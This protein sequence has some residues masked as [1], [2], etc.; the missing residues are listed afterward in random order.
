MKTKRFVSIFAAAFFAIGYSGSVFASCGCD[1]DG[2]MNVHVGISGLSKATF[3]SGGNSI[4]L[5]ESN[6]T[7]ILKVRMESGTNTIT[8]NGSFDDDPDPCDTAGFSMTG[9]GL[10]FDGE[11][12]GSKGWSGDGLI[13]AFDPE[14]FTVTARN[15][16]PSNPQGGRPNGTGGIAGGEAGGGSPNSG[17]LSYTQITP[18][19]GSVAVTKQSEPFAILSR[20]P[21]GYDAV[22]SSGDYLSMGNLKFYFHM[23]STKPLFSH[24]SVA[25]GGFDETNQ[26]SSAN[27]VFWRSTSG[28]P[29]ILVSP[30]GAFRLEE[31]STGVKVEMFNRPDY[32]DTTGSINTGA[33]AVSTYLFDSGMSGLTIKSWI[34]RSVT[35]DPTSVDS[36]A[37]VGSNTLVETAKG[38]RTTTTVVDD[39]ASAVLTGTPSA[40]D[41]TIRD[42]DRTVSREVV[43]LLVSGEP[44]ISKTIERFGYIPV[45]AWNSSASPRTLGTTIVDI[46][47]VRRSLHYDFN[48]DGVEADEP[49]ESWAYYGE[50][51][52]DL[53][54]SNY[55][56]L[57]EMKLHVETD[58][59]WTVYGY[60]ND[61]D[62]T[63]EITYQPWGD[64]D[65]PNLA[66]IPTIGPA[67][68][69]ASFGGPVRRTIRTIRRAPDTVDV[70][71]TEVYVNGGVT[72]GL[73]TSSS[74][75]NPVATTETHTKE[76]SGEWN[77]TTGN[78]WTDFSQAT[79]GKPHRMVVT[80]YG[81][82]DTDADYQYQNEGNFRVQPFQS[83]Q[84][85]SIYGSTGLILTETR[86]LTDWIGSVVTEE[87]FEPATCE[88][89]SYDSQNRLSEVKRDGR[90]IS[91][92]QY[93]SDLE[94]VETDEHGTATLTRWDARGRIVSRT[95]LGG[96]GVGDITTSYEYLGLEIRSRI[97]GQLVGRQ[98]VDMLGRTTF[99]EDQTGGI[100]TWLYSNQGRTVTVVR[101]DTGT[102]ITARHRDGKL[103]SVTGTGVVHKNYYYSFN[104]GS[105]VKQYLVTEKVGGSESDRMTTTVTSSVVDGDGNWEVEPSYI[106]RPNAAT[107]AMDVLATM[108]P[109]L[110]RDYGAA[111]NM[112]KMD[113]SNTTVGGSATYPAVNSY[114]TKRTRGGTMG[115]HTFSGKVAAWGTNRP[116]TGGTRLEE[117]HTYYEKDEHTGYWW[118]KTLVRRGIEDGGSTVEILNGVRLWQQDGVETIAVQNGESV[119]T[120]T[121][122]DRAAK[123]STRISDSTF[124]EGIADV[125]VETVN[126]YTQWV[127]G[128]HSAVAGHRLIYTYDSLG[129][130]TAVR[131]HRGAV[132]RTVYN[133]LG[134]VIRSVDALGRAT[135][136]DY[137]AP[138]NVG[139]GQV[140]AITKP[141]GQTSIYA[142]NPRGQVI[143]IGGSAEYP[144]SFTYNFYGERETMTTT[145]DA[146]NSVTRW[147]YNSAGLLRKKYYNYS[148]GAN[149][150]T[151]DSITYVYDPFGR[152]M[153][154]TVTGGKTTSYTYNDFDEIETIDYGDDGAADVTLARNGAGNVTGA[155]ENYEDADGVTIGSGT[156]NYSYD[157]G[158]LDDVTYSSGHS[159]LPN[160]VLDYGTHEDGRPAGYEIKR[161][162][163]TDLG[164]TYAYDDQGRLE[165]VGSVQHGTATYAYH[166]GSGVVAGYTINS[167]GTVLTQ[168]R[169]VDFQGRISSVTSKSRFS[170]V[171]AS[172]SYSYDMDDRR[173]QVRRED[174]SYWNYG[175]NFR[176]EVTL[177]TRHTPSGL[178]I[179][180]LER[181]YNYDDLGNRKWAKFGGGDNGALSESHYTINGHNQYT[182]TTN[183]YDPV[184]NTTQPG[185]VWV[186]GRAPALEDVHVNG[187][188][189]TR[190]E[191]WFSKEL[192]VANSLVPVKESVLVEDSVGA[193]ISS[194]NLE[195]SKADNS[196]IGYDKAGNLANDG[197]WEYEW[198]SENRLRK[199]KPTD[200]AVTA[201]MA[202]QIVEFV[203][204]WQGKRI[205]KKV[206]EGAT[207]RQ[208]RY[209]YEGWNVVAEWTLHGSSITL[210][211]P[212]TYLWGL[213]LAGQQ[214]GNVGRLQSAGGV[215]GLLAAD[216]RKISDATA[217][218]KL[219]AS[220]DGNGNI[221]AWSDASGMVSRTQDYDAFGNVVLKEKASFGPLSTGGGEIAYG[222]STKPEDSESG[223]L[224]YGYRYYDPV[225][226]RW[227]SRDPIEERGGVN[228]YA[229]LRNRPCNDV[230]VLG[231]QS[232]YDQNNLPIHPSQVPDMTKPIPPQG[233]DKTLRLGPL[234]PDFLAGLLK[235]SINI[236]LEVGNSIPLGN[237][238]GV[239]ISGSWGF[240]GKIVCCRG[241]NGGV[242]LLAEGEITFG[243]GAGLG[244]SASQKM[245]Q[246]VKP[247]EIKPDL[248]LSSDSPPCKDTIP[249]VVLGLTMSGQAG[250]TGLSGAP[251]GQLLFKV[252]E[253]SASRGWE[254][255]VTEPPIIQM[256]S[257]QGASIDLIGSVSLNGKKVIKQP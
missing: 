251:G 120:M 23:G 124:V 26:T 38:I 44:V 64:T 48:G 28:N 82:K 52:S 222:F 236:G 241:V 223:L 105:S 126:G 193:H 158:Q 27:K 5:T 24:F 175:Y 214:N 254:W 167:S 81:T 210:N 199:M 141:N 12:V 72:V 213:D 125:V 88:T 148:T 103:L 53:D 14:S 90:V 46:R 83:K 189:A 238:S 204:D 234:M 75:D 184:A 225:S 224:Y 107:G 131:D 20:I 109:D 2:T 228:V 244:A 1:A 243:V 97:N 108:N 211:T 122:F 22:A 113:S 168:T 31:H 247:A 139:A 232:F 129:R 154:K 180:G 47:Q 240:S 33:Q 58:R 128:Q 119:N 171:I 49:V 253:Y 130:A 21:L 36:Y 62:A 9:C 133:S 151:E 165:F 205:A 177:A 231:K 118:E 250:L 136:Y 256:L 11:Q 112:R 155:I 35:G 170:S 206:T 156:T 40:D 142:Y 91:T 245:K 159:Y 173:T 215:G 202:N 106:V 230:D 134:Q 18:G 218:G 86:M 161:G 6:P 162:G 30:E 249:E 127:Q 92:F 116:G 157:R 84:I 152:L 13:G 143:T 68:S 78:A 144:Q 8:V 61:R 163:T 226:G 200:A 209:L 207:V 56:L 69:S 195:V 146:G 57:G 212:Q 219:Y 172:A 94:T 160:L 176:G 252:G 10:T 237:V 255:K 198:D 3:A 95:V 25:S 182:R 208:T 54:A 220:Y 145:N 89:Y 71:T 192:G 181:R 153:E 203:Y 19:S 169:P 137:V 17:Q 51:P 110:Q 66:M 67:V 132:T 135:R 183:G 87:D 77:P 185:K 188:L 65:V 179:D 37:L 100:T 150:L 41:T 59:N 42:A 201:G 98:G 248:K 121:T 257:V 191:T 34:R 194:G 104:G 43:D 32:N 85:I 227:V 50:D 186:V 63:Q 147:E 197:R 15:G 164:V 166:P 60:G 7:G 233:S 178:S 216:V 117:H 246:P 174:G 45:L 102:E 229:M 73:A 99:Q 140:G 123:K 221:L 235:Y 111:V 4:T 79:T 114:G 196:P 242:G 29:R 16:R 190:Q 93:P 39:L 115:M 217:A 101:P 80:T 70:Q 239:Q 55:G 76:Y 138:G 149:P 187:Q 74:S 96:G